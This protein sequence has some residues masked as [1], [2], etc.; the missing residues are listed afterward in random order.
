MNYQLIIQIVNGLT[1]HHM[2][3]REIM[4]ANGLTRNQFYR[5]KERMRNLGIQIVY[6]RSSQTYSL[7]RNRLLSESEADVVARLDRLDLT[8]K[9]TDK[10]LKSLS[11]EFHPTT[12]PT[13][14][15][16]SKML[17]KFGVIADEHC[18]SEF[19]RPDIT[20]HAGANFKRQNVDFVV[21]CGDSIEGMSDRDG[22]IFELALPHGLG[23]TSQ[24]KYMAKEFE[25]FEG[26]DVY[27]I[28]AQG[29]HGGWAQ[30][31]SNQGLE[32]GPYLEALSGP[33]KFI[34]YDA[35]DLIVNGITIRLRHP[36]K[37]NL[38][39]YVNGLTGGDKPHILIDGHFHSKAG[40]K[41]HRNVHCF[42]A[43]CMQSQTPFLKRL[44][45]LVVLGYWIV[46]IVIG[47][48]PN[49]GTQTQLESGK[50]IESLKAEFVP[51]Y[52]AGI[53][54]KY[55]REVDQSD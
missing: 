37:G 53:S 36:S 14:I 31:R 19:Y 16:F 48:A 30:K 2:S 11:R 25:V 51:F 21:N 52:D 24:A 18:G 3:G 35:A 47:D 8:R 10:V 38:I 5:A 43:G 46:E 23:V 29:S 13:V 6:N 12:G 54:D 22:H 9:Q 40:Y 42:D 34:G 39:S 26:L 17:I 15:E 41:I 32:I 45:S 27:S 20:R 49:H 44:G 33:Y 55:I 28:E 4:E 50:F 1:S 7:N